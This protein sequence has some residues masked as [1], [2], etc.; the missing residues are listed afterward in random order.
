MGHGWLEVDNL[1]HLQDRWLGVDLVGE[2]RRCPGW[3]VVPAGERESHNEDE[4][5]DWTCL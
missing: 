1:W 5:L 3:A 2:L 4:G